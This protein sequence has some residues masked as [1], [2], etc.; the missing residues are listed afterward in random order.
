[1]PSYFQ[2]L[3]LIPAA[4]FT[5]R[6]ILHAFDDGWSEATLRHQ[7]NFQSVISVFTIC[8][9]RDD[10]LRWRS[11][12]IALQ[13]E[14]TK[15]EAVRVPG[16]IMETDFITADVSKKKKKKSGEHTCH[17]SKLANFRC[18]LCRVSVF[19]F[20]ARIWALFL[21]SCFVTL[22]EFKSVFWSQV[23]RATVTNRASSLH[24]YGSLHTN[25]RAN[26]SL[27]LVVIRA[28]THDAQQRPVSL[29]TAAVKS[30]RS[31]LSWAC[32]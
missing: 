29:N 2:V 14:K 7:N 9:M 10:R 24:F 6:L 31:Q 3:G 1:M 30:R 11:Q 17:I 18:G 8:K 5:S 32:E 20:V 4:L 27:S 15:P 13:G 12:M 19:S 26:R 22:S 23:L 25:L 16:S 21:W 28:L